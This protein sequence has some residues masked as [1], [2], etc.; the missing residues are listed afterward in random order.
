MVLLYHLYTNPNLYELANVNET[1]SST[2]GDIRN[3]GL[4]LKTLLRLQ[5]EIIIH[6]AAQAL[7][8]E[9]YN[10]PRETYEVNVMGTVNLLDAV[11]KVH[12]V[13]AILNITSDKCYE[14]K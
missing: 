14:N 1:V 6:M 12:S 8:N 9:S 2:I 11:R 3:Y 10:N 4:L 7:V 5:P 13:K